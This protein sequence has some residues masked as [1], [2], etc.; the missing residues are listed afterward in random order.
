[1][2]QSNCEDL[3][4]SLYI[5]QLP[6]GSRNALPFSTEDR[7]SLAG[8]EILKIKPKTSLCSITIELFT[9]NKVAFFTALN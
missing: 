6:T 5:S 8:T 7:V 2:D 3:E 9:L 1:M 4:T